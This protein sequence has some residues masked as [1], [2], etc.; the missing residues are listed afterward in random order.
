MNFADEFREANQSIIDP[1]LFARVLHIHLQELASLAGVHHTTV[2]AMPGNAR[3]QTY[4]RS[5]LRALSSSFEVT[6]DRN[7]SVFWFRNTRIPEF[8][9]RTAEQLV[10]AGK[11]DV[12]IAYV[13]SI[14][15][16]STG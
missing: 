16:G 13:A 2:S 10:A 7:R 3:L 5:A 14:A 12:V 15:S 4:L 9:Y 6:R 11:T 1:T 8:D